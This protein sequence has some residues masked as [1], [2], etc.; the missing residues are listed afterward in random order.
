[1]STVGI[2]RA[3]ASVQSAILHEAGNSLA[4]EAEEKLLGSP[5]NHP[6]MGSYTVASTLEPSRRLKSLLDLESITS[7]LRNPLVPYASTPLE[8]A[9]NVCACDP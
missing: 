4:A 7:S 5:A 9:L 6:C 3:L 2:A 8:A 1:M